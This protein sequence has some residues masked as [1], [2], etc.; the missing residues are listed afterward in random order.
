MQE[1]WDILDENRTR[2]GRTHRRA[3]NMR[4]GDYHLVVRLWIMNSKGQLLIT[5]RALNKIGFPGMWEIPS[6][7]VLAGGES[8]QAAVRE[9]REECGITLLPVNGELASTCRH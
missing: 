5:R 7:S 9:A 2:T 4:P 3:D 6:G 1:I 8:L